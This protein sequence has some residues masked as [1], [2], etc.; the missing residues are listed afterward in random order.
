LAEHLGIC[1]NLKGGQ[2]S[3]WANYNFNSMVRIGDNHVGAGDN[4]LIKLNNGEIDNTTPIEA[5]FELVKSDWGIAHQKRIRYIHIGFECDGDLLLTAKDDDGNEI[6]YEVN[7]NH[8]PD[9]QHSAKVPGSRAAKGRYW[10]MR[11]ENINGS[12]FSI[13][14][15]KVRPVILARKP[16]LA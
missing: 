5:F 11:I 14:M 2:L 4:G 3:Q 6:V 16:S 12:D 15:I 8:A 10:T 9:Q 13:D 1:L 7:P